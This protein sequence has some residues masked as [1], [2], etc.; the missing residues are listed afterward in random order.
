VPIKVTIPAELVY[1]LED[2]R[3]YGRLFC[4]VLTQRGRDSWLMNR[5]AVRYGRSL[6]PEPPLRAHDGDLTLPPMSPD[7]SIYLSIT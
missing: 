3:H 1:G 4:Q 5:A 2:H 6:D 7:K